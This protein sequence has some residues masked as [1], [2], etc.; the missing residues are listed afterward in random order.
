MITKHI[1]IR[2]NNS[3][4]WSCL[5]IINIVSNNFMIVLSVVTQSCECVLSL[6]LSKTT[7]KSHNEVNHYFAIATNTRS[8]QAGLML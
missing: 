8:T 1:N 5:Y 3:V 2:E 6:L 7:Y 4:I